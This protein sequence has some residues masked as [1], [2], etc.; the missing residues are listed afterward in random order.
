[1]PDGDV[2]VRLACRGVVGCQ[3]AVAREWQELQ[4]LIDSEIMLDRF[5]EQ[6]SEDS[7]NDEEDEN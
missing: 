3:H 5:L 6:D 1:V 4:E 7:D 2:Q